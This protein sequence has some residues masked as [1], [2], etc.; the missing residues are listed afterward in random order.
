MTLRGRRIQIDFASRECQEAFFERI[1][2]QRESW[3]TTVDGLEAARARYDA[4]RV[5]SSSYSRSSGGRTPRRHDVFNESPRYRS[6]EGD[7][8]VY[9]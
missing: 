7:F 8:L 1:E 4:P 5:R 6:F 2:A 3:A 9:G